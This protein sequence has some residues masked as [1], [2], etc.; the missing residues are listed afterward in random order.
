M[1]NAGSVRI[2]VIRHLLGKDDWSFASSI[3]IK[4]SATDGTARSKFYDYAIIE[5]KNGDKLGT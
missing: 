1:E 4:V 5:R 2:N 3:D